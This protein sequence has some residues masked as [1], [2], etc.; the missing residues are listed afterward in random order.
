MSVECVLIAGFTNYMVLYTQ[1][2]Y[3][4]SSSKSSILVGGVIVPS[5]ILGSILGGVIVRK[6]NLYIEGCTRLIIASS[7]I[8]VAG[9]FVLLFIKCENVPSSGIDLATQR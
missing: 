1:H 6:F 9:I 5:A 4:V 7:T 2:V 3:Q 8:V